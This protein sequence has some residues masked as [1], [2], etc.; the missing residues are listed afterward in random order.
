[1]CLLADQFHRIAAHR[2]KLFPQQ[3]SLAQLHQAIEHVLHP[4]NRP[5]HAIKEF[6]ALHLIKARPVVPQKFEGALEQGERAAKLV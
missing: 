4:A 3:L 5:R 6:G 2:R 1:M